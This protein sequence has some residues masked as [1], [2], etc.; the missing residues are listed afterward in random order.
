MVL[1]PSPEG[2]PCRSTLP[3]GDSTPPRRRCSPAGRQAE[4]Q[5]PPLPLWPE[6]PLDLKWVRWGCKW[7]EPQI[8]QK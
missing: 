6:A 8:S 2:W 7:L 4:W 3:A 5:P 1:H